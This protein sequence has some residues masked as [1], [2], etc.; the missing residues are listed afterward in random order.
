[1][2]L[3]HSYIPASTPTSQ[4]LDLNDPD[5]G[6]LVISLR[7]GSKR[8]DYIYRDVLT[9]LGQDRDYSSRTASIGQDQRVLSA[10]L[11]AHEVHRLVA[12]HCEWARPSD[13]SLDYVLQIATDHDLDLDLVS[14]LDN[15]TTAV[16]FTRASGGEHL[17]WNPD[18]FIRLPRPETTPFEFSYPPDVPYADF[19]VFRA[20][21]RRLLNPTEFMKV[22]SAYTFAFRSGRAIVDADVTTKDVTSFLRVQLAAAVNAAHATTII[23][24]V[25]AAAFT[26]G[27]LIKVDFNGLGLFIAAATHRKLTTDELRL[28]RRIY[29]PWKAAAVVLTDAGLSIDQLCALPLSDVDETGNLTVDGDVVPV[30]HEGQLHLRALRLERL[31]EAGG[32]A[33][34]ARLFRSEDRAI[35]TALYTARRELGLPLDIPRWRSGNKIDPF[36][37]DLGLSIHRLDGSAAA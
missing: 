14:E 10:Y 37:N 22:D 6:T 16:A 18:R 9:A 3:T 34:G 8:P 15:S 24:A 5:T 27:L 21:C 29:A 19:P 30:R 4:L 1:M 26:N 13:R 28:V 12:V 20:T 32:L 35:R 17:E 2:Q 36:E 25:Q 31:D 11:R 33:K 7:P 23:R